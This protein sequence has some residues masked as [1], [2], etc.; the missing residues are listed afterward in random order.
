MKYL[1]D[2]CVISE[3]R[4]RQPSQLLLK[5]LEGVRQATRHEAGDDYGATGQRTSTGAARREVRDAADE[6]E[7]EAGPGEGRD[8][9]GQRGRGGEPGLE[10]Q[11]DAQG[12]AADE[13]EVEEEERRY[14][15]KMKDEAKGLRRTLCNAAP[16]SASEAPTTSAAKT[17][18]ASMRAPR[19]RSARRPASGRSTSA[20]SC[21]SSRPG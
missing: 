20:S 1:L 13:A 5:W 2:T 14:Q 4:K 10:G 6:R 12:G 17:V 7:G 8:G 9:H 16:E 3:T 15:Q 19:A 21:R 11:C 18:G